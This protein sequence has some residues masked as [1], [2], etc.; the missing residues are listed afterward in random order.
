VTV[1]PAKLVEVE[2]DVR[3][4]TCKSTDTVMSVTVDVVVSVVE[5]SP[6]TTVLV[7][8]TIEVLVAMEAGAV[9]VRVFA[10]V[11]VVTW[12]TTS[13]TY[14]TQFTLF[15]YCAA[16]MFFFFA[17]LARGAKL[18]GLRR[19]SRSA[20]RRFFDPGGLVEPPP[21]AITAG[22]EANGVKLAAVLAVT[23]GG[24][25][26]VVVTSTVLV[27]EMSTTKVLVV[28]AKAVD[29]TVSVFCGAVIVSILTLS[30]VIVLVG[31]TVVRGNVVLVLS[32]VKEML[33]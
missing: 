30:A 12:V 21:A 8:V 33:R 7:M 10:A 13:P 18:S 25:V 2:V 32:R 9:R 22:S 5:A 28:V 16:P 26:I 29:V 6:G 27:W 23:V 19:G 24:T 20:P 17:A 15:G 14:T 31:V 1:A 3:L 4:V 11:T